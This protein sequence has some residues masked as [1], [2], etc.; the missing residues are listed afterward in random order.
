MNIIRNKFKEVFM[1]K[2]CDKCKNKDIW[3]L[4]C[5]IFGGEQ[6]YLCFEEKDEIEK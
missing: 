4:D 1:E 5:L 2:P 6:T 3:C